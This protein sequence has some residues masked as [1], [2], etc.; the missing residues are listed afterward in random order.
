MTKY[1]V[2]FAP[3]KPSAKRL[4]FQGLSTL[5]KE[6]P[7]KRRYKSR[8]GCRECKQSRLKCD[9]MYPVC[10]RCSRRGLVCH[11]AAREQQWQIQLPGSALF[12]DGRGTSSRCGFGSFLQG[13]RDKQLLQ[14]W[15]EKTSRIFVPSEDDNPFAY[16]IVEH[17]SISQSLLHAIKSI[18]SAHQHFFHAAHIQDSLEQRIKAMGL[19]RTEL[20]TESRPLHTLFLSVYLLGISSSFID[21]GLQDFGQEHLEAARTIINLI[22][23]QEASRKHPLTRLMVGLF[24]YWDMSCAFLTNLKY[25][26]TNDFDG[27]IFSFITDDMSDFHHPV[28]GPCT[29]LFFVLCTLGKY[30]RY[31]VTSGD[32]DL[33]FELELEARLF[34]WTC[35]GPEPSPIWTL[36]A[37]AFR[38]HGM[39]MLYRYCCHDE[40]SITGE[41]SGDWTWC[42][43]NASDVDELA[44]QYAIEI[45]TALSS[46]PITSSYLAIQGIPLLTAG[47]ELTLAD[48]HFQQESK[49]RFLALY[50]CS[51]IP[52][53]LVAADL[54]ERIWQLKMEGGSTTWLRLIV[55]DNVMLRIG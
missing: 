11:A 15:L 46:I 31:V 18:S 1:R 25:S 8:H 27:I 53:N 45:I 17:L 16:P 21:Q 48:G 51:R 32:R 3:E 9:E 4:E 20:S 34:T 12:L 54:L 38:K 37:E 49:S 6:P 39:I 55:E 14:Y 7:P 29:E 19:L 10:L 28:N 35:P 41:E 5:E 47:A 22:L 52:A 24:V 50:S 13:N 40:L 42:Q 23:V 30:I 33:D 26:P 43:D 44:H 2:R 36:T